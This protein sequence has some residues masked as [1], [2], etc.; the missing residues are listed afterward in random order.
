MKSTFLKENI[1][2]PVVIFI[3]C[4]VTFA[5]QIPFLGFALDDWMFIDFYSSQGIKGL[6]TYFYFDNRPMAFWL[7]WIGFNLLGTTPLYWQIWTLFWKI[8]IAIAIWLIARSLF[9]EKPVQNLLIALLFALYPVFRQQSSALQLSV[10][11]ICFFMVCFSLYLT[12]RAIQHSKYWFLFSALA[13]LLSMLE[14]FTTEFFAGFELARVIIIG[15]LVFQT[16]GSPQKKILLTL[17]QWLPYLVIWVG[18]A[19]W[20]VAYIPTPGHDRNSPIVVLGFFS[21]PLKTLLNIFQMAVQD[22]VQM[23]IGVW[24]I[25][26]STPSLSFT[27]ISNLLSWLIGIAIILIVFAAIKWGFHRRPEGGFDWRFGLGGFLI[28]LLGFIPGWAIGNHFA[29]GTQYTD[30]FGLAAIPGAV[31]FLITLSSLLFKSHKIQIGFLTILIGLGAVY[32][33]QSLA[34]YRYSWEHQAD[35]Y[36]QLK[37]RAP[38]ITLPVAFI[39]NG[40]LINEMGDWFLSPALDHLYAPQRPSVAPLVWYFDVN[41][42][43]A[44]YVNMDAGSIQIA[45]YSREFSSSTA[46]SLVIQYDPN[47][48]QCLWILSNGDQSNPLVVD[49][50]KP[51]LGISNINKIQDGNDLPADTAVFGASHPKNWCY[52]FQKASLADQFGKWD[53][54]LSLWAEADQKGLQPKAA[55]EYF[56]F[57][58]SA[59]AAGKWDLAL[60]ISGRALKMTNRVHDY[61]CQAWQKV[62][63]AV[64]QPEGKKEAVQKAAA[65]FSCENLAGN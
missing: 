63:Q 59:T 54:A 28:M 25:P 32:H 20:R 65:L 43:L 23:L 51:Y 10:H 48:K 50:L 4:I 13:L 47:G 17:K 60:D 16:E 40:Q 7:P 55:E 34:Q 14:L 39:G 29:A 19:I 37:W 12:V 26:L 41:N 6:M 44:D 33:V 21:N 5:P 62:D 22:V 61:L 45:K 8:M 2:S 64:N 11:M 52:Y 30:R 56:P 58:Q 38:Q 31:I 42:H 46:D 36:W 53:T 24:N 18:W 3:T 57:I 9:P 35:F 49:E 27:P 1:I 15:Y